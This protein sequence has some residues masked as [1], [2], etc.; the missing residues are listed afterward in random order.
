MD[1]VKLHQNTQDA[2]CFVKDHID[3]AD[4]YKEFYI[5]VDVSGKSVKDSPYDAT[6][7]FAVLGLSIDDTVKFIGAL[8]GPVIIL[9]DHSQFVG[10]ERETNSTAEITAMLWALSWLL[11]PSTSSLFTEGFAKAEMWFGST[12]A[13]DSATLST[14]PKTN[15]F[16]VDAVAAFVTAVS[17]QFDLT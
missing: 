3:G 14:R 4:L 7:A 2:F 6:W 16:V 17:Y 11:Q 15:I 12:Y 13:A 1:N 10:C 9:Q 8:S 5:Y